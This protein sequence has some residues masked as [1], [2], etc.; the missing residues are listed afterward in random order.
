MI[1]A[2]IADDDRST[3]YLLEGLLV[4]WGFEVIVVNNGHDALEVMQG[5]N[6]P[7]LLLLDW[8]M[9]QLGGLEVCKQLRWKEPLNPP[10]IIFL[11]LNRTFENMTLAFDAGA[12]DYVTKPCNWTELRCRIRVGE[13]T[14]KLQ[15]QLNA[16]HREMRE[17]AMRDMLTGIYNRRAVQERL[18]EELARFQRTGAGLNIALVDLDNFKR[19]NDTWG[20][21][22]GDLVLSEFAKAVRKAMRVSD[23]VGRWG[24]DE[25]LLIALDLD[26][27]GAG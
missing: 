2:L 17:L 22:A 9:P 27:E 20:H 18:D 5:E 13:R 21:Q 1:K 12:S 26:K 8:E 4:K 7:R 24:G 23:V 10:Y 11:T 16:A 19:V 6:P 3:C 25:F 15:D 14:L